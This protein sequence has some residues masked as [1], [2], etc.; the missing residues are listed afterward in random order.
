LTNYFEIIGRT[1]SLVDGE[2]HRATKSK[3]AFGVDG[4]IVDSVHEI[5]DNQ[6]TIGFYWAVISTVFHEK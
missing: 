2:L 1:I 5:I 4:I 6:I 3:I